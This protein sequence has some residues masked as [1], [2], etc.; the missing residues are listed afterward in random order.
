MASIG[1]FRTGVYWLLECCCSLLC[2][3]NGSCEFKEVKWVWVEKKM[4][5]RR[6][7]FLK[8]FPTW[9]FTEQRVVTFYTLPEQIISFMEP[10]FIDSSL[11]VIFTVP[12]RVKNQGSFNPNTTDTSWQYIY[13]F[14]VLKGRYR[15][16][17]TQNK[18]QGQAGANSQ[19][20]PARVHSCLAWSVRRFGVGIMRFWCGSPGLSSLVVAG[21]IWKGW[22]KLHQ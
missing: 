21:H 10:F 9:Y 2:F 1:Q 4:V 3:V 20:I 15:I 18:T 6:I 19:H 13:F 17:A 7:I 11:V 16:K 22:R 12:I 5:S 14:L 8:S